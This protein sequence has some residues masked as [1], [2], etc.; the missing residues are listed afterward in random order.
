MTKNRVRK[1]KRERKGRYNL[2]IDEVTRIRITQILEQFRASEDEG[3]PP[4]FNALPFIFCDCFTLWCRWMWHHCCRCSLLIPECCLWVI[5]CFV[6]I[7]Y[8]HVFVVVKF[9]L[10]SSWPTWNLCWKDDD[11]TGVST[12]EI[13][14]CFVFL[15]CT[16]LM[17]VC[18]TQSVLW[19]IKCPRKWGLDLKVMGEC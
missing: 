14:F 5:G 15:Q 4:T 17:L 8:L 6:W 13:R 3:Y 19:C 1:G 9:E 11:C 12:D 7:G 16:S 18:P 2:K 10:G